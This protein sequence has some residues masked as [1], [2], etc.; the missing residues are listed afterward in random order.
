MAGFSGFIK[1]DR[2]GKPQA[3]DFCIY[4]GTLL[5]GNMNCPNVHACL[6]TSYVLY[7]IDIKFDK[8]RYKGK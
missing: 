4:I 7:G 5:S 1:C 8:G 3:L 6:L 2:K